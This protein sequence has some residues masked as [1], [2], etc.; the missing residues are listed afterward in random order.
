M[1]FI[2]GRRGQKVFLFVLTAGSYVR[3][4]RFFLKKKKPVEEHWNLCGKSAFEQQELR[5]FGSDCANTNIKR[6]FLVHS[7]RRVH[8]HVYPKLST[9]QAWQDVGSR[10]LVDSKHKQFPYQLFVL[11]KDR[12]LLPTPGD[13]LV[14]DVLVLCAMEKLIDGQHHE[15]LD[16]R[17]SAD[18]PAKKFR[19]SKCF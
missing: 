4:S 10:Q 16:R 6:P 17:R 8:N 5:E 7:H 15:Q 19:F 14:P 9:K 12:T 2:R 13:S 3:F 11:L 1:F 18:G